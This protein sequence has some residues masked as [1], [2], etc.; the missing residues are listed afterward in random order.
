MLKKKIN[1]L[2]SKCDI[3]RI[4]HITLAVGFIASIG[5]FVLELV[6]PLQLN[7]NTVN[8]DRIN[9]IAAD[10]LHEIFQQEPTGFKGIENTFRAGLFK[11]ETPLINKPMADKTVEKIKSQ[12]KLQ[13]IMELDGELV[14]YV[15]I[16]GNGMKKCKVGDIVSDLFTVLNINKK[17]IEIK[18]VG[19]R[20]SLSF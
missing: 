9:A 10:D 7:N 19:H 2:V 11:S 6:L 16:K 3:W 5:V 4:I 18:I 13:C 20:E 12:L 1:R 14:A 8:T 15:K 17:G